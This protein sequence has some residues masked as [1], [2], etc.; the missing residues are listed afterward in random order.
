MLTPLISLK[1]IS[2]RVGEELILQHTFWDIFPGQNWAVIGPNGSGKTLL[3]QILCRRR[4]SVSGKLYYRKDFVPSR[5]IALVSFEAQKNLL[6][7]E[8]KRACARHFSGRVLEFTTVEELLEESIVERCGLESGKFDELLGLTGVAQL[9]NRNA[10]KLST[11]EFRKVLI[12]KALLSKPRLFILDE[13]LEGLDSQARKQIVELID[14]LIAAK[15]QVIIVTHRLS[16]L[17]KKIE[18]VV[19]L[20]NGRVF[21]LGKRE[22]IFDS[23]SIQKLYSADLSIFDLDPQQFNSTHCKEDRKNDTLI[24]MKNVSVRFSDHV[25]FENLHWTVKRGENWQVSGPNGSGKSTL[26]SL[27]SGDSPQAYA[28]EIYL[29]GKRRGSGESIWDIKRRIGLISSEFQLRY[30]RDISVFD[31]VLSGFFDSVGL[32][33]HAHRHQ[34]ESAEKWLE[35]I[36]F[37]H[38]ADRN[39]GRLSFGEQKLVLIARA[40]VKKPEILILDEPCQGLDP[41]NRKRVLEF[42]DRIGRSLQNTLIYVTHHTEEKLACITKE[43][44]LGVLPPANCRTKETLP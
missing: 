14:R 42:I 36:G 2:T 34:K 26:L 20:K 28:N 25:V 18:N 9:I 11:G 41:I 30:Q 5:D 31:V 38:R 24:V 6:S 3:T 44:T 10:S 15:I 27:I 7:Q 23:E 29:F 21:K 22:D 19:C 16:E 32:Y 4:P 12:A 33:R 8:E 13:P 17:P 43:L 1:N 35:S 40:M 37:L 39:F